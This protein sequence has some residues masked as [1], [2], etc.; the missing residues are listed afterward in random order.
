VKFLEEK[1]A[2][3]EDGCVIANP[4]VVAHASSLWGLEAASVSKSL[5][6]KN[7]GTRSIILVRYSVTQAQ[8]ARDAMV[9]RV[10]ADLFQFIVDRI[11][12]VLSSTGLTRNC[13]IGVL[14]IFGFESFEINSFEQLCINYCNEKLQFHFNEHIFRLEQTLYESEGITISSTAFQDNQPTLDLLEAKIVGIFS[15]CDEEISVPRGS[16]DGMLQKIL[17][18]HAGKHPNLLKP[19]AKDCK[20]HLKSFGVLHYAGP[21]Y[22][23][24]ANFLE[25]NKDQVH[26]DIV[27]VLKNSSLPILQ[28]LFDTSGGADG[29]PSKA[30]RGRAATVAKKPAAKTLGAQFKQQ[31]TDLMDTLN[32]TSPHFIRCMKPNDKKTGNLF[33]AG[34]MVDQLRYAGLVE[35]CRIRKLG[36]PVRRDFDPFLKRYR[37]CDT[38]AKGLDALLASLVEQKVLVDGE[39]AK[40]NTKIFLRTQQSIQLELRREVAFAE[41]SINVQ[42]IIRSFL[43]KK[44]F[45]YWMKLLQQVKD[46]MT[47]RVEETLTFAIDMSF[48][49]PHGGSHLMLIKEAKVL[50]TRL[51]EENRVKNLLQNAISA[52]EMSSLK[53]AIAAAESMQP[54]IS[55]PLIGE[56]KAVLA[57]LEEENKVKS[58]LV[59]AIGSRNR[60]A[61]TEWLAKA[62]EMGM[63]CNETRQATA[64][65][66]RLEEEDLANQQLEKA[67]TARDL[68]TLTAALNKCSNMGL[69]SA[70]IASARTLLAVLQAEADAKVAVLEAVRLRE[71]NGLISA[72]NHAASLGLS[73]SIPEVAEGNKLK[74]IL[75][76]EAAAVVALDTAIDARALAAIEEAISRATSAGLSVEQCSS[77][78]SAISLRDTILSENRCLEAL[79][80]A[81]TGNDNQV[82]AQALAE[83]SRL[84][85]SGQI[86]ED[87]RSKSKALGE[88]SETLDRLSVMAS[89]DVLEDLAAALAEAEKM[90]LA[91]TPEALAAVAKMDRLKEEQAVVD[92]LTSLTASATTATQQQLSR[93]IAQAMRMGLNTKHPEVMGAAKARA[94]AL[95]EE[96]QFTMKVE[97]AFRNNDLAALK[98]AISDATAAN[99]NVA[100]GEKKMQELESRQQI[101]AALKEAIAAKNKDEVA[102]LYQQALDCGL[103]NET[104]NQAKLFADRAGVEAKLYEDFQTAE[105]SMN[106]QALNAAIETAIQLGLRSAEVEKAEQARSRLEVFDNAASDITAATQVVAVKLESG[107]VESD[108]ALLKQAIA[109]AQGVRVSPPPP[110]LLTSPFLGS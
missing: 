106:L 30:S 41:V 51:R 81:L 32:S 74:T 67:V 13:F 21:V 44:R 60:A 109:K 37:C 102:R 22:Y 36:Y 78:E 28:Q 108:L 89:G 59:S 62:Q 26:A 77:L 110:P 55:T 100:M 29:A 104:V 19:K 80:A 68:D 8:D 39:W 52:R 31:L 76:N 15:M 53:S 99:I 38:S 58:E 87:A 24:V 9:K 42:K 56:A 45:R 86:V 94:K 95:G 98:E 54:P 35:V 75:E 40:G 10:Y 64:L 69:E 47:T 11:N 12:V 61:L 18:K 57:R 2:M 97:V 65:K 34:R 4:D 105:S 25:K 90:G 48:E 63:D 1:R 103:H 91:S 82:L 71:L 92:E 6:S 73:A 83:A 49:L 14:D 93:V 17:Q 5:T 107:I 43:A 23:N 101:T 79:S 50:Q 46:G 33:T 84:G 27:G 85:L 88:R 20:D 7:I 3:E 66:A 70:N 96:V 72:L 16:D